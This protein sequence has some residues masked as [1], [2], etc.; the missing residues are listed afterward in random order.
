MAQLLLRQLY[1][2]KHQLI[3]S[4]VLVTLGMACGAPAL[5][6]DIFLRCKVHQPGPPLGPQERLRVTV[7]GYQHADPW[8]LPALTTEVNSGIWSQW[9]DLSQWPWHERLDREGGIAEW[10]SLKLSVTHADSNQP[11]NGCSLDVELADKPDDEHAVI[12]FTENS[13]SNTIGF[14]VPHPLREHA[15]EFETGTQMAARHLAW[16]KAAVGERPITLHKFQMITSLWG[17]YD[18]ALARQEVATLRWLGFD[19]THGVD[20]SIMQGMGFKTYDVSWLYEA[21]PATADQQWQKFATDSLAKDLATPQGQ[22]KRRATSHWTV[23]DE[24][25]TLDFKGVDTAK[26]NTWF[27]DYLQNQ[28]VT[29]TD[30]NKPLS[31][32]EYPVAAM[33]G[34]TLPRSADLPTRRLMY[35]AAKFGQWWSARQL[36]HTSELIKSS[37]AGMQTETLPSDHGFLNAWGPPY[38]G[39]SYPMLDLFEV[40]AQHSVDQLSA[41]DWLGLNHMYG[42]D[43]T[44]TGAQTFAYFNAIIRSA[45]Q[46]SSP[47]NPILQRSLI[48][49]SDDAFLRLKA[50]SALGQGSKSFYFWTYGP[51]YIGTENYWSDLRSEYNGIAKFNRALSQAEDVLYPAQPVRDPVAILYSVSHDIWH[52]DDPAAF[53]EKRLLWHALRHLQVQPDF[54]RE[55]DLTAG[56]LKD[57]KALYITDWCISRA[58]SAAIDQWVRAGGVVYLSAGAATRDE[59]YEPYAP[60]FA[61][62]LWPDNAAHQLQRES[63]SYNERSDLPDIKPLTQA[64]VSLNGK[65][66]S[67]PVLGCRLNLRAGIAQPFAT[68]ADHSPAGAMLPYGQGQVI[69]VGFLPMLAYAQGAGFKPKTLEEKWPSEPRSIINFALNQAKVRPVVQA[70][71]RVVETSLLMGNQGAAVVLANYTYQPIKLLTVDLN[72]THTQAQGLK[73][74]V[75]TEGKPVSLRH[76]PH[77]VRLVLPLEWT[78][79]VLL[80]RQ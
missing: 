47:A 69:G 49:P 5:A 72:L 28:G 53:V 41:E 20:D 37:L 30:L 61:R 42:P 75:S 52:P 29:A 14:L 40:G 31:Q 1:I 4:L 80:T 58:A 18:P 63:H 9:L 77:G 33:H 3:C 27:R 17:P 51:T 32:V 74:A 57:Y 24:I 16:A 50:Y 66:F 68:F 38:I 21:D 12:S 59:F 15:G 43:T 67:L 76:T 70:N 64:T 25:K 65:A 79:I 44:W 71:V 7:T 35:Y 46:E 23:A 55:E 45:A 78:D 13:A 6:A 36:R 2:F 8:Y 54:M 10:P 60:A 48:T 62:A 26:L 73:R 56:R 11:V 34:K 19:T 22:W 39:M